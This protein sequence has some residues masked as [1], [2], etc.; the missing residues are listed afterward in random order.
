LVENAIIRHWSAENAT[1]GRRKK[2]IFYG[3]HHRRTSAVRLMST[4]AAIRCS[5]DSDQLA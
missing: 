4:A 2:G 1:C 5:L 3:G